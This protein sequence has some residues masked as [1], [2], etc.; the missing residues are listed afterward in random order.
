MPPGN[1]TYTVNRLRWGSQRLA[2]IFIMF[3]LV[4]LHAAV[5]MTPTA[6]DPAYPAPAILYGRQNLQAVLT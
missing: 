4:V 5:I 1:R 3:L 6:G 2:D